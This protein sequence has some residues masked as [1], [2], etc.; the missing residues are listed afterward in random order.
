MSRPLRGANG[1]GR[2]QAISVG[3][4]LMSLSLRNADARA[5]DLMLDRAP[6]AREGA[7]GNGQGVLFASGPGSQAGVS[8]EHIKAVEKVLNVLHTMPAAEPAPD[9]LKR[10]LARI[11]SSTSAPMQ[12][13]G[14]ALIDANRPVA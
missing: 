6:T 14:Q 5:V 10:T 13:A 3:E 4:S 12:G 7:G 11:A 2:E 9:L 1:V 8:N